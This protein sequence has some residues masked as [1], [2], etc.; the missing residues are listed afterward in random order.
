[1]VQSRVRLDRLLPIFVA[2]L[3][4]AVALWAAQPYA[5]GVFHDDGVYV[6][7]GKS[8]ATGQ[9]YRFLH[10]PGAPPATHYPPAYPLLL[11]LLWKVAPSFPENVTTFLF[12]NA[13]LLGVTA[14]GAQ[15]FARVILGWS[16]AA[17]AIA[18]IVATLSTPLL[19]LSSLVLSEPLFAA[20]LLPTLIAAERLVRRPDDTRATI[21]VSIALGLLALVRTHA[22]ALAI[23][24][25]VVLAFRRRWRTA[26]VCAAITA[27]TLAPW[28]LWLMLH[29]GTIDG[30]LRGSYGTYS[31]WLVTGAQTGGLTFV[32]QTMIVNVREV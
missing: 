6:I 4:A 12:A 11:S 26:L 24:V 7:L 2:A 16:S 8:I 5:V 30:T 18:A 15:A 23:A 17:S 25:L 1:M 22:F 28:H 21:G 19:M 3:A 20:L 29:S 32:I 14:I 9:G 10:L 27:A 31:A 13:L